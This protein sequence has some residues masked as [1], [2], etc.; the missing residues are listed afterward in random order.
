MGPSLN[1]GVEV[2][3]DICLPA[4]IFADLCFLS[5]IVYT[6]RGSGAEYESAL[7]VSAV[8]IAAENA[9]LIGDDCK[10]VWLDKK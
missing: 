1:C 3:R 2:D 7:I 6:M 4:F 10:L 8:L 5:A 9:W